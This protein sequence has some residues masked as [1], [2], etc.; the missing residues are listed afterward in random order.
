MYSNCGTL[1]QTVLWQTK[2]TATARY[3]G[4]G[5]G[6]TGMEIC[7]STAHARTVT[8]QEIS[9]DSGVIMRNELFVG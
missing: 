6:R 7:M 9:S 4:T 8:Y 1:V 2:N 5:T 3:Q